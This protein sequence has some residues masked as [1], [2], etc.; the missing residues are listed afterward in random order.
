MAVDEALMES[1][2]AGA[3]PAL[4]FYGWI[5]ACLSLGRNQSAR[6]QYDLE[7]LRS[8][9]IDVVRRPTG[10]RAVLHD[11]EVTYAV[12]AQARTFGSA[13]G[14][15]FTISRVLTEGLTNLGVAA[16]LAEGT[17]RPPVPSSE[18]CFAQPVDGEVL[19]MGRKL[20]GSAQCTVNGVLLQHGSIPLRPGPSAAILFGSSASTVG[21]GEPAYLQ[22]AVARPVDTERVIDAICAAWEARVAEL[23]P[24]DLA[25]SE[26][27]RA[28]ALLASYNDDRW[29]WRG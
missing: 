11:A 19:A 25:P 26:C 16:T 7:R 15:Y 13:R 22:R 8:H 6:G 23:T 5:P 29:T 17:G 28:S 21:A 1:V 2:R 20:V 4:R 10:G 27:L 12:V 3:P 14:A 18:P 9:N 24:S